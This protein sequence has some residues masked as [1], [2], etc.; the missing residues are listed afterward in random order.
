[1]HPPERRAFRVTPNSRAD[2]GDVQPGRICW[3]RAAPVASMRALDGT[4]STPESIPRCSALFGH[5]RRKSIS[6]CAVPALDQNAPARR[7]RR[8]SLG[9]PSFLANIAATTASSAWRC[10]ASTR[11]RAISDYWSQLDSTI[12]SPGVC[13]TARPRIGMVGAS[14]HAAPLPAACSRYLRVHG[15]AAMVFTSATASAGA[16]F[17]AWCAARGRASTRGGADTRI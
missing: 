10:F 16:P 7:Y 2:Q 8:G 14:L 13:N 6:G 3:P 4:G 9:R 5:E 11:P 17:H 12:A 15:A 1:M